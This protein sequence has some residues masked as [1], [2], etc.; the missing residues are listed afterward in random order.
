MG[1]QPKMTGNL[2]GSRR[3]FSYKKRG[4]RPVNKG[5]IPVVIKKL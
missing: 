1:G 3:R 2:A 5:Y 4:F